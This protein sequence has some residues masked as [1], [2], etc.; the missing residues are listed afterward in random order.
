MIIV[1]PVVGGFH[2]SEDLRFTEYHRVE[3]A[4]NAQHMSHG[5]L[6]RVIVDI[7]LDVDIAQFMEFTKPGNQVI[8][9]LMIFETAVEFR[10]IAGRE[11]CGL[12]DGIHS[13]QFTQCDLHVFRRKC[14][15]FPYI[16][17]RGFVI[18]SEG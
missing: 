14:D 1:C 18:N 4:G 13:H 8:D 2:L 15:P 5:F 17:R 3:A 16:H 12:A 6:I 9:G 7:R 11:Y 10:T